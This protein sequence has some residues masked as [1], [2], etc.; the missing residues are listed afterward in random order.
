MQVESLKTELKRE[1]YGHL[2]LSAENGKI[3][4]LL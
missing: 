4:M 1:R 2:K 3:S